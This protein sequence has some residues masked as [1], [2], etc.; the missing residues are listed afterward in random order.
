MTENERKQRQLESY[1]TLVSWSQVGV[2]PSIMGT[3]PIPAIKSAVGFN[4]EF[5]RKLIIC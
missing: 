4:Y 3:G 5:L 1:G 2:D